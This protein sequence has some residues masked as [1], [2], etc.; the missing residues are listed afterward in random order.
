L[1]RQAEADRHAR[2]ASTASDLNDPKRT[3][4]GLAQIAFPTVDYGGQD[5]GEGL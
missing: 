1:S 5:N 4:V 3:S 2:V